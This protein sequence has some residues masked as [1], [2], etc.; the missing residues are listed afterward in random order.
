MAPNVKWLRVVVVV[1]GAVVL[2]W[3]NEIS[4]QRLFWAA[5]L[6]IV[7]IAALEVLVG[8]GTVAAEADAPP[9]DLVTSSPN[10]S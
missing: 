9:D 6:T 5:G 10:R 7:L 2:M 1:L 4:V 3:G 8:A